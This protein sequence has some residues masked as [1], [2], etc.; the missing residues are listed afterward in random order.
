MTDVDKLGA[1]ARAQQV[2][3]ALV[4]TV[5]RSR[6]SARHRR[7]VDIGSFSHRRGARLFAIFSTASFVLLFALP[8]IASIVY[9][10]LIASPQYA[11][12]TQFTLRG[13]EPVRVDGL[14]MTIGFPAAAIIQDTQVVTNYIESRALVEKLDA[15]LNLRSVFGDKEFDWV[16]RF[17]SSKPIEKLVSY[18]K[19]MIDV[20]IQLP[21]GIVTVAVRTFRPEDSLRVVQT[22]LRLSEELVNDI[23]KRMLDDNLRGAREELERSAAR[24]S[25][26]RD[27]LE[28]ARNTEGMLDPTQ[29]G[30]AVVDLI[31]SLRADELKFE[32][33]YESQLKYVSANAPQ[34][35]LLV[36]RMTALKEQI[37]RLEDQMTSAAARHEPDRLIATTMTRFADLELEKKIAEKQ[38]A[39]AAAAV[40]TARA[41]AERKMMYLQVFVAPALPHDSRHP[42]RLMAVLIISAGSAVAWAGLVGLV[43]LARNHM[44]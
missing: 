20:N 39:L 35:R 17:N 42:R 11:V 24:L 25:R 19:S 34:V 3:E 38:Y 5:R 16:A 22:T 2:R 29:T 18:W 7:S 8:S 43:S 41:T 26:A 44:A 23:N 14:G 15:R 27:A 12:Q 36:Q 4:E 28:L 10:G 40:E 6:L 31:T 21:G 32:R 33:E 9:F 1:L 13:G 37:R 30:Q